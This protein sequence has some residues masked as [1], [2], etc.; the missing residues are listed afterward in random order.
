MAD[1][2]KIKSTALSSVDTAIGIVERIPEVSDENP[3]NSDFSYEK[4]ANPFPFLIDLIRR[5][6]GYD[7][8][9]KLI[10]R[11]IAY[12]LPTVEVAVKAAL[13]ANLKNLLY[14]TIDPLLR[15]NDVLRDGITINL[16]DIDLTQTLKYCP[17]NG[18]SFGQVNNHGHLYYFGCDGFEYPSQLVDAGDFNAF[19]W[20]VINRTNKRV[21]WRGTNVGRNIWE[22]AEM[23][24]V[25]PTESFITQKPLAAR[26]DNNTQDTKDNGIITLIKYSAGET[27]R[28]AMGYPHPI[29]N[30]VAGNL[31]HVYIGN[32]TNTKLPDKE[33]DEYENEYQRKCTELTNLQKRLETARREKSKIEK[34]IEKNK[35]DSLITVQTATLERWKNT[36]KT[37]EEENAKLQGVVYSMAKEYNEM[38]QLQ[39]EPY[40]ESD[41][42]PIE[43]NYYYD[44]TLMKFNYDYIMS[45]K[46]FDSKVVAAQLIDNL[47]NMASSGNL[48]IS[49]ERKVIEE[50]V[51][52]M[53][54]NVLE[55]GDVTISD[56]FFAFSNEEI[57]NL[58]RKTELLRAGVYSGRG[59]D[60]TTAN[61]DIDRVLSNL[62]NIA[63]NATQ[64]EIQSVI[65]GTIME[66]KKEISGGT[67]TRVEDHMNGS[68]QWNF[69]KQLQ[70]NLLTVIVE[71]ICSPKV[72]LVYLINLQMLGKFDKNFNLQGF[73][74]SKGELIAKIITEIANIWADFL[75]TEFK[76]LKADIVKLIK[77]KLVG[78]Q[79]EYYKRLLRQCIDCFKMHE[80]Y[81]DFDI[82]D[83]DYAD[84]LQEETNSS[85]NNC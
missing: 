8:V 6:R 14:C 21:V 53:L 72:Y 51:K 33:F 57:N 13:I 68:V 61:V 39:V 58:Q 34:K 64:E 27:P 2:Q 56:C 65:E 37:L 76:L 25:K 59:E 84:I 18:G 40:G 38:K 43:T 63:D 49:Y 67:E 26:P 80:E 42:K 36:I 50:E 28:D 85:E 11:F 46:L 22:S 19:L 44:K 74:H 41:Y 60:N 69:V 62:N 29:K 30:N 9:I 75:L 31:I 3:L 23:F 73:L 83:V 20:Y 4:S 52:K 35:D 81:L 55:R 54:E 12:V 66:V 70:E 78:E 10:A 32:T 24:G 82:D 1:W 15:R 71:T 77:Q 5:F 7:Y 17:L 45:I 47:L 16:D 48:S 79:Y